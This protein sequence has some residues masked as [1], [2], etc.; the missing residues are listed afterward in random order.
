MPK[1]PKGA[2]QSFN[3]QQ[4]ME[5]AVALHRRGALDRAA[6]LY[7][8]ILESQPD[9]VDALQFLGALRGQ[10]GDADTAIELISRALHRGPISAGAHLSLAH[11]FFAL[12]RNEDAIKH[13]DRVLEARPDHVDAVYNRCMA[14]VKLGRQEEAL[15]GMDRVLAL[16]P[17]H[18]RARS[19]RGSVLSQLG[20]HE[21]AIAGLREAIGKRN[22]DADAHAALALALLASGKLKEGWKEYEW[23]W[24]RR[25]APRKRYDFTPW[26]GDLERP[27]RILLWAEQGIGDEILYAGMI[28][29]LLNSPL[30]VA[31]E[32][33]M[34]LVGLLQRSF[35]GVS[36]VPRLDPPLIDVRHYDCQAPF[37]TLGCWLRPSLGAFPKQDGYLRAD[38]VRAE[39][40]RTRLL[41]DCSPRTRLVGISWRSSNKDTG[42]LKSIGLCDWAPVLRVPGLRFVNLQYGDTVE[43][44]R[45][46]ESQPG[47]NISHLPELDLFNDLD[48]V[49][50]LCAACDLVVT[51]SNVSAHMAGALGRPVWL[52]APERRI[53][54]YW[55]P[56]R[57]DSPWYPSMRIFRQGKP[58][59]WREV[60]DEIA[61]E[62]R[63]AV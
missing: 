18:P 53:L 61:A 43:E 19:D 59:D 20:R 62:L 9:H 8:G 13:Y 44:R 31:V 33:D 46:A 35:P 57:S 39:S 30:R 58:E 40:Y 45:Q 23:R 15:T 7:L 32:T 52:L 41:D 29:E 51:V 55:F 1:Q 2:Q 11:A 42:A 22:D 3:I 6:Q 16:A 28:P 54:W 47:V 60:L 37:A 26:D 36:I 12:D 24:R 56:C 14:L 5:N 63:G 34:R 4:V 27:R 49:A 21:E 50:A 17:D 48:G 10:Q 25:Q 38:P